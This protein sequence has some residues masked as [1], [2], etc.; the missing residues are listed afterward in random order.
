MEKRYRR[1]KKE[2]GARS[3]SPP[4]ARPQPGANSRPSTPAASAPADQGREK[5]LDA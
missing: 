5:D 4:P 3:A 1:K 2:G